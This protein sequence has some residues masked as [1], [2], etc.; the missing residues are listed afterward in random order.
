MNGQSGINFLALAWTPVVVHWLAA[1]AATAAAAAAAAAASG[2]D[3]G[4]D[5]VA[6]YSC[7]K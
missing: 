1:A 4:D 6:E 5:A 7:S 3:E 2:D